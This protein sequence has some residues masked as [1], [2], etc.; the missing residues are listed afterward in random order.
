[1]REEGRGEKKIAKRNH[2]ID[3]AEKNWNRA[4]DKSRKVTDQRRFFH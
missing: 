2:L 4:P 3:V 1:M